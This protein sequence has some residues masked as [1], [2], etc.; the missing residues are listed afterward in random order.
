MS[1][2]TVHDR[3][4]SIAD[5][6]ST[7]FDSIAFQDLLET[8]ETVGESIVEIAEAGSRTGL[9]VMRHSVRTIRQHPRVTV[10]VVVAILVAVIVIRRRQADE[11]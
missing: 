9:R 2:L 3:V 10:G 7:A 4:E 5:A 11:R 6:A 1:A 8:A